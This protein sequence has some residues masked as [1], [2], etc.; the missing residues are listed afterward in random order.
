MVTL[1]LRL[2]AISRLRS[3]LRGRDSS[4]A[5]AVG[6]VRVSVQSAVAG[7]PGGEA[8]KLRRMGEYAT[9][10]LHK[11]VKKPVYLSVCDNDIRGTT[12]SMIHLS[13][14]SWTCTARCW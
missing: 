12:R 9:I 3:S 8:H 11:Q 10:E 1:A 6:L 2:L 4:A 13:T 14:T 5:R 7:M